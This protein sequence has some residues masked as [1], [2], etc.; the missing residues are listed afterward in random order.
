MRANGAPARVLTA[1]QVVSYRL[2][3]ARLRRGWTQQ[4]A[5]EHLAPYLGVRW[6]PASFSAA[7]RSVDGGRVRQFS[8]DDLLA[9]ARAF[10]LP[11]PSFLIPPPGVRVAC[12]DGEVDGVDPVVIVDAVI[13]TAETFPLFEERLLASSEAHGR[14]ATGPTE[15]PPWLGASVRAAAQRAFGSTGDC[16]DALTRVAALLRELDGGP[17]RHRGARSVRSVPT[18]G[19]RRTEVDRKEPLAGSRPTVT[20]PEPEDTNI[21]TTRPTSTTAP[22]FDPTQPGVDGGPTV[23]LLGE[24]GTG[25]SSTAKCIVGRLLASSPGEPGRVGIVDARGEYGALAEALGLRRIVLRPGGPERLNPLDASPGA[26]GVEVEDRRYAIVAALCEVSLGRELGAAE[27][28]AV[29]ATVAVLPYWPHG[30]P[31]LGDVVALLAEPSAEMIE[32][33]TEEA[34]NDQLC[35]WAE[36]VEATA[37]VEAAGQLAPVLGRLLDGEMGGCFDGPTTVPAD[38]PGAVIDLTAFRTFRAEETALRLAALASLAWLETA[39]GGRRVN[40]LDE[41]WVLLGDERATRYLVDWLE[42]AEAATNIVITHRL[43]DLHRAA[44]DDARSRADRAQRF[45]DAF[46]T[47]AAFR[48]SDSGDVA[49]A[50][51]ALHITLEESGV[52]P[53]L[54]PGLAMWKAAEGAVVLVQYRIGPDEWVFCENPHTLAV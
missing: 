28:R 21:M 34:D 11:L 36:P 29:R 53:E 1:N 8:A 48:L 43:S 17:G 4:E 51:S 35:E 7:E 13:G 22:P 41:A 47:W 15:L 2:R 19:S 54:P 6:S 38:G 49:L 5:A 37:M 32:W 40:L 44:G 33:A 9:F 24:P 3:E 26:S 39:E 45:A 16:I 18:S 50:R 46:S 20:E 25:K 23:L 42:R 27:Q 14:T 52:L 10:D 30:Q 31:V 12:P